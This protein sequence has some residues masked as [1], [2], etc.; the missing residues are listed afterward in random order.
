MYVCMSRLYVVKRAKLV[1]SS[2]YGAR[3][4]AGP[5]FKFIEILQKKV[6]EGRG[7]MLII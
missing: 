2:K 7:T 1:G 5:Q 6:P 4:A 3:A